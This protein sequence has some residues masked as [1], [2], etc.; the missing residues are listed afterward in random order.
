MIN[1]DRIVPITAIDLIS[2]YGVILNCENSGNVTKL[3]ATTTDGQFNIDFNTL[4]DIYGI[5]SEPVKT[6]DCTNF[7]SGAS[8]FIYFVPAYDFEGF[9]INGAAITTTGETIV[10]DGRTLYT[11]ECTSSNT[12]NISKVGF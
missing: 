5:C 1:T 6:I 11:A 12:V 10:A 9:S 8:S 4:T 3:D 7:P 2:M